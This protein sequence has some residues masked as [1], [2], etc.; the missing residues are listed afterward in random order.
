VRIQKAWYDRKKV[1]AD[2]CAV[3][4]FGDNY[5]QVGTDYAP[6]KTQAV[7]RGLPNAIGIPTK[8]S[9]QRGDWAYLTDKQFEQFKASTMKAIAEAIRSGKVIVIP[10]DGIGTGEAQLARWAPKCA[11]FLSGVLN[12]LTLANEVP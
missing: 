8:N 3:Y 9:P 5:E 2:A 11:A 10:G 12:T 6:S 7:I 4:L 1:A